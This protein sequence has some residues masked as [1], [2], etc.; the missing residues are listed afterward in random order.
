MA[1][2]QRRTPDAGALTKSLSNTG[3]QHTA[4]A[5]ACK[6]G[7][8]DNKAA[9]SPGD[10]GM[11]P[12]QVLTRLQAARAYLL[13]ACAQLQEC[14]IAL[15]QLGPQLS[16]HSRSQHH[17]TCLPRPAGRSKGLGT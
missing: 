14:R 1:E 5:A 10:G 3:L 11:A 9:A 2:V 7:A 16:Q 8:D 13:E 4:G 15:D 17:V 6:Q 12:A